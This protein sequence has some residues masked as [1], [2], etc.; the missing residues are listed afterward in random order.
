M[1]IKS[2]FVHVFFHWLPLGVALVFIFGFMYTGLQQ[3]M[4]QGLNDPQISIVRDIEASVEA[5]KSVKD[6]VPKGDVVDIQNNLSSFVIIFDESGNVLESNAVLNGQPPKVPQGVLDYAKSYGENRVTWQPNS[7]TRVALVV[8][9]LQ[10]ESGWFVASG[11]NMR[12]VEAR[13]QIMTMQTFIAMIFTLAAT[14]VADMI[15]DTYRRRQMALQS[16]K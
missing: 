3:N 12:E 15:G 13:I 9:P 16:N 4:R 11:R 6:V 2:K 1:P 8:R 14:F 7:D 10:I 5:G